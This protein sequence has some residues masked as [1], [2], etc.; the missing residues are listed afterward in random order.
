MGFR[1]IYINNKYVS[2][3]SCP[4]RHVKCRDLKKEQFLGVSARLSL[5]RKFTV[6]SKTGID[7]ERG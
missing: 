4:T 1:G 7:E 2:R 6:G 5:N 3:A